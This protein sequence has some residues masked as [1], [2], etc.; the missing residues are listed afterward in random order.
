MYRNGNCTYLRYGYNT[1]H[2]LHTTMYEKSAVHTTRLARS[3]R[4]LAGHRHSSSQKLHICVD[5][6]LHIIFSSGVSHLQ[7]AVVGRGLNHWVGK[8]CGTHTHTHTHTY[9]H[10]TH[11]IHIPILAHY[12]QCDY[13][14]SPTTSYSSSP[15]VIESSTKF[16]AVE[17]F[18]ICICRR[19]LK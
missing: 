12:A 7:L 16:F 4:L 9:T 5:C 8:L 17:F 14:Y 6:Y 19:P 3:L 1:T 13:Y 15:S 18:L 10:N 2:V 11:S